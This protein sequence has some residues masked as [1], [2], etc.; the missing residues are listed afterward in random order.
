M[1]VVNSGGNVFVPGAT[2]PKSLI[3]FSAL[4][5]EVRPYEH[6]KVLNHALLTLEAGFPILSRCCQTAPL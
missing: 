1:P 6:M 4:T 3:P 5:E 2:K